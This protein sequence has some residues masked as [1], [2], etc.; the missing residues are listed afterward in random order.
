MAQ[1]LQAAGSRA[2]FEKSQ[3]ELEGH[4]K[5]DIFMLFDSF[6]S[7]LFGLVFPDPHIRDHRGGQ[8]KNEC[9]HSSPL[10]PALPPSLPSTILWPPGERLHGR[11]PSSFGLGRPGAPGVPRCALRSSGDGGSEGEEG[12]T[13]LEVCSLDI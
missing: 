12:R 10:P 7:D 9:L 6:F 8:T 11:S 1:L 3:K 2:E 4:T 5:I 13:K